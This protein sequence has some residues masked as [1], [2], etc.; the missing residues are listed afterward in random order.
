MDVPETRDD[1]QQ[2]VGR[3]ERAFVQSE[4]ASETNLSSK[5]ATSRSQF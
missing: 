3:V 5:K 2:I 1:A 4:D